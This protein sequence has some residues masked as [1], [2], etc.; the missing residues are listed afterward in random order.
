L[1]QHIFSLYLSPG[2]VVASETCRFSILPLVVDGLDDEAQR[3]TD[4]VDI[5]AHD[6]LDN[7]GLAGIVETPG[8]ATSGYNLANGAARLTASG[9]E[10]PCP[11]TWLSE[12][13]RAWWI[14]AEG[15]GAEDGWS[16]N[17]TAQST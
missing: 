3:G 9:S 12:E 15:L 16:G 5:L 6:P 17:V 10:A 14:K 1:D 4:G 13:S 8:D 7:G 11:S 2:L